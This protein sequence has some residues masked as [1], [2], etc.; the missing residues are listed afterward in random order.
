M[1]QGFDDYA[2]FDFKKL[3]ALEGDGDKKI[4]V[5]VIEKGAKPEDAPKVAMVYRVCGSSFSPD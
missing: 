5:N 4:G 1:C 3:D 2:L